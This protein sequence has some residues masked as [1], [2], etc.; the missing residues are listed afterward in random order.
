MT[1]TPVGMRCPECSRQKTKV[2]TMGDVHGPPVVTRAIIAIAVVVWAAELVTRNLGIDSVLA[3]GALRADFVADGEWWRIVTVGFLHDD[4]LPMGLL[5]I[6]FNMYFL[7]I[8][9]Q[10]LEPALGRLRFTVAFFVS[11]LGGSLGALLLSPDRFTVGASGAVFGLI[12]V[13]L[14]ELR[15]RG[16]PPMRTPLASILLLNLVITFG[17]ASFISVGGHLGGLVAGGVVGYLLFE[18]GGARRSRRTPVLAASVGLGVALAVGS[19]AVALSAGG[20]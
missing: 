4:R 9:G 11:L 16:I 7:Y 14:I 20:A 10:M 12:A 6:G 1:P 15:S 13:A 18:I 8:L 19:I 17:F 3:R 2:V 5:H